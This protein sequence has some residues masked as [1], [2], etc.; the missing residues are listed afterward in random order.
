M[1]I[2]IFLIDYRWNGLTPKI[3]TIITALQK[4]Q[5]T[6]REFVSAHGAAVI[7]LTQVDVNLTQLEHLPSPDQ[8]ASPRRRLQQLSD[9]ESELTRQSGTLRRADELA[10]EIMHE[11]HSNDV[12]NIQDLVDEYQQLYKNIRERIDALRA[13][14][15]AEENQEVD[16]AVQ[17]E[18]LKFETDTG[19]QVDT[20]PKLMRMTSFDAYLI[21]L[22][23]AISECRVALDAL[24]TAV[25][26]EPTPGT[27]LSTTA[28]AIVSL[29]LLPRKISFSL[30]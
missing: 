28:R 4:D 29:K 17:V 18:T 12:A 19:V 13:K 3:V 16:E 10:L 27:G 21:E 1:G 2:W 8:K 24:E 14:I 20:L 9:V 6:Y 5:K 30:K 25:L 7:G 22:E 15:T 11:G 26:P 23:S